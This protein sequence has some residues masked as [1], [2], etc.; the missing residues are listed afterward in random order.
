[1]ASSIDATKPADNSKALTSDLRANLAAAKSEIEALQSGKIALTDLAD[2]SDVLKGDALIGGKRT[3]TGAVAFTLHDYNENRGLNVKTDFGAKGDGVTD[4]TA[5][6]QAAID[7]ATASNKGDRI[8]FPA[9]VYKTTSTLTI[10]AGVS[11]Y[12][13]SPI[14]K[15]V[16]ATAI[17]GGTWLYF[18]HTGKGVSA[19]N[20]N[21]V[22][23]GVWFEGIGTYRD[24]PTPGPAYTPT[25]HDF[26]FYIYGISEVTFNDILLL[27][28]TK[29]IGIYNSGGG[30]LSLFNIRGQPLTKGIVID[31]AY[32]VCRLDQIH[33]W[34]FWQDNSDVHTWTMANLDAIQ[35]IRNDNP[36]MSNIFT[37]FARAGLQISQSVN[38]TTSKIHLTNADFDRGMFGIWVDSTVIGSPT[39]QFE[40]ITHQGETGL[41]GSKAVFIQGNNCTF[42]FGNFSTIRTDQ[43]GI[44][45][46]GTGNTLRFGNLTI[47]N[48][49]QGATN[50]P[51]VEALTGNTIVIT[52]KPTIGSGGGG[53]G[54]YDGAGTIEVDD[55]RTFT[56]SVTAQTGTITTLG[57]L[58]GKY[59]IVNNT[60]HME[61]S[62]VITTNGTAAGAIRLALPFGV[63]AS[64]ATGSGREVAVGG[65]TLSV[66]I[67]GA[68]AT[69]EILNYDNSY[70]G[71]AGAKFNVSAVYT[72]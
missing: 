57:A 29:G 49:D 48:Y 22:Y 11:F 43:N 42:D 72:R 70:P 33:F 54:S 38:G 28:P 69:A 4:D 58:A 53:G 41:A 3:A 13:V 45:V 71:S 8:F 30:K 51:A 62:I 19:L 24:Q 5:A 60:V 64:D 44:R 67:A 35:T 61:V 55:W 46:A 10:L 18:A 40:N 50:F 1:M 27:N 39:G 16:G 25:S 59:K 34:P 7:Y 47:N 17:G 9:G 32:D 65:K 37:I 12:G 26:D 20:T 31:E 6:I 63:A 2:T 56:P 52:P 14:S 15:N 21:G 66:T 36:T 68:A 23:T